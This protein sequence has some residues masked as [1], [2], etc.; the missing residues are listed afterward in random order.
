MVHA[1]TPHWAKCNF[2]IVSRVDL[3]TYLEIMELKLATKKKKNQTGDSQNIAISK[4]SDLIGRE[5]GRGVNGA[6]F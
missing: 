6:K 1:S 3:G 2:S 4:L 5:R